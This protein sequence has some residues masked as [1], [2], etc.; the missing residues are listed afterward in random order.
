MSQ[1]EFRTGFEPDERGGLAKIATSEAGT[2]FRCGGVGWGGFLGSTVILRGWQ[3][4]SSG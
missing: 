2:N 1:Y 3:E 4:T